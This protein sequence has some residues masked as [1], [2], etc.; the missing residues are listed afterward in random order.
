MVTLGSLIKFI[1]ALAIVVAAVL[2]YQN[3]P[4]FRYDVTG[5]N[6]YGYVYGEIKGRNDSSQVT[7][8]LFYENGDEVTF[9]GTLSNRK[10]YVKG[11]DE[12]NEY[13]VLSVT[14]K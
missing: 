8:F 9:S 2:V 6:S 5:E 14:R 11:Y 7:G 3:R 12:N 13:I 4:D 10:N 1:A